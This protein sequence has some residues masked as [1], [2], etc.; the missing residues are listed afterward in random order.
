MLQMLS[1]WAFQR[2]TSFV[3]SIEKHIAAAVQRLKSFSS[4]DSCWLLLPI[5]FS[6]S[7]GC[8]AWSISVCPKRSRGGRG[9]FLKRLPR[10]SSKAGRGIEAS[11]A[12]QSA[13]LVQSANVNSG[14]A[15][16]RQEVQC[17]KKSHRYVWSATGLQLRSTHWKLL[18]AER[19]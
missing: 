18:S 6:Q 9:S 17:K 15:S 4:S 11:D 14:S 8:E 2:H 16:V 3:S 19:N 13:K 5:S 10:A 1:K 12:R 7:P